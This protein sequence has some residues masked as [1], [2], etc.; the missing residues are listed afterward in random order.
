M[1][2]FSLPIFSM[3]HFLS[4][5]LINSLGP[6]LPRCDLHVQVYALISFLHEF[7]VIPSYL[8]VQQ[9]E[10]YAKVVY[11]PVGAQGS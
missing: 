9:C 5:M 8:R 1:G 3:P 11:D 4:H 2:L 10:G 6:S 7:V